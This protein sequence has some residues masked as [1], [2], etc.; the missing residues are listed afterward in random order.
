MKDGRA[1][2]GR[3]AGG[4]RGLGAQGEETAGEVELRVLGEEGV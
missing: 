4:G 3:G 2:A 1:R